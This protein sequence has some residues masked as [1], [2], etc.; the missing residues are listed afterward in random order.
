MLYVGL[1]RKLCDFFQIS[2]NYTNCF[3]N[4]FCLIVLTQTGMASWRAKMIRCCPVINADMC[5]GSGSH[6]VCHIL[7]YFISQPLIQVVFWLLWP[8]CPPERAVWRALWVNTRCIF[9]TRSCSHPKDRHSVGL[10]RHD[11]LKRHTHTHTPITDTQLWVRAYV[12]HCW[13]ERE[14]SMHV[15]FRSAVISRWKCLHTCVLVCMCVCSHPELP[16]CMLLWS[17]E[18]PCPGKRSERAKGS[19][20]AAH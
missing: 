8:S 7:F 13:E 5:I 20:A 18:T 1:K 9:T 12:S 15:W 16:V 2:R 17:W 11:I 4:S 6:V 3:A 14:K 19:H 10:S